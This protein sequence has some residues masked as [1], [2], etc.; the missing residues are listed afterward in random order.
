MTPGAI[1]SSIVTSHSP[2]RILA[3]DFGKRRIGLALSDP[4][5]LTAQGLQTLVRTTLREDLAH[6]G[7]L[8][9]EREVTRFVVG[10][11]VN[12]NG[13]EG[14]AAARARQFADKLA[15]FS[16]LPVD[17][18]DERLTSVEAE[19]LFRELGVSASRRRGD[20]DRVAA[21]ILLQEYLDHH[22]PPGEGNCEWPDDAA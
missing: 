3:L 22:R 17:L 12:M 19:E 18:W 16:G 20:V 8:A 11:P 4:L 7:K 21:A 9:A 5:G 2:A 1:K 6:I 10:L 14:P 15:Q 13:T